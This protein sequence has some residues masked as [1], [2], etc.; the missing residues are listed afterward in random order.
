M[1]P[2]SG[3]YKSISLT[4]ILMTLSMPFAAICQ[5]TNNADQ[6]FIDAKSD[7]KTPTAYT[8][9]AFF[10]AIGSGCLGGSVFVLASQL[11]LPEPPAHRLI[12]KPPEYVRAYIETY[13]GEIKRQRLIGTSAGC[14]S[15][16]LIA[17]MIWPRIF[18][19]NY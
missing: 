7:V 16:S 14:I 17:A 10:I 18:N 5:E 8:L 15:G 12:G 2:Y 13:E 6:A 19:I 9:G 11:H 4:C 3:F 1:K